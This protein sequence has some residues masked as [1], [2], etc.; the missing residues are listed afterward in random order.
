MDIQGN[1]A[2]LYTPLPFSP[3]LPFHLDAEPRDA[4]Q[5]EEWEVAEAAPRPA[6]PH[7]SDAAAMTPPL[8]VPH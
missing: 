8:Q 5:A 1:N 3:P 6:L 4:M 2:G 7:L